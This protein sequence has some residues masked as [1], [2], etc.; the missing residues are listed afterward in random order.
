[1]GLN[2][3]LLE[4]IDR[5]YYVKVRKKSAITILFISGVCEAALDINRRS[6]F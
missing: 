6:D 2:G 5:N 3:F 4:K 1:M